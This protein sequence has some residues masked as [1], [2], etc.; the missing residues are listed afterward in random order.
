M[1]S[2]PHS[3]LLYTKYCNG[4]PIQE[5]ESHEHLGLTFLIKCHWNDHLDTIIAKASRLN[6]LWKNKYLLNR[7]SQELLVL[8]YFSYVRPLLEYADIIWKHIRHQTNQGKT[9]ISTLRRPES[10]Q[11]QQNYHHMKIFKR[12]GM[13]HTDYQQGEVI[14]LC[15][16]IKWYIVAHLIKCISLRSSFT[17]TIMKLSTSHPPRSLL[18]RFQIQYIS[19]L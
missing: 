15:N 13:R 11:M 19:L 5:A 8:W 16:T 7:R 17:K 18:L 2:I 1:K 6:I 14:K 10:S 3:T 12:S 9:K 4:N